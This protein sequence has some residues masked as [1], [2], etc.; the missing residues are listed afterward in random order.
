MAIVYITTEA[1]TKEYNLAEGR[2]PAVVQIYE[3]LAD[4]YGIPSMHLG[5]EIVERAAA[6]EVVWYGDEPAAGTT[7]KAADIQ[8]V[9]Y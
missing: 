7:T 2:A 1:L 9:H 6:G 4:H 3:R 8:T 5:L